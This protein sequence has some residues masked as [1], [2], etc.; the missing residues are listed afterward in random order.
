MPMTRSFSHYDNAQWQ[1]ASL[2]QYCQ[3]LAPCVL[4]RT[5]CI[6]LLCHLPKLA[7]LTDSKTG[8]VLLQV[9]KVFPAYEDDVGVFPEGRIYQH[10]RPWVQKLLQHG[11]ADLWGLKLHTNVIASPELLG[12]LPLRHLDLEI[13]GRSPPAHLKAITAALGQ[14]TTLEYL[15]ISAV[16]YASAQVSLPDLCR[17]K[18]SNLTH[19]LLRRC[20]PE[21]NLCL[22]PG[23]QLRLDQIWSP[24]WESKW[25][26]DNG[27]ELLG[28]LPAVSMGFR[29]GHNLTS[30]SFPDFKVVQYLHLLY[31]RDLK[32]LAVLQGIPHVEVEL[33]HS[34]VSLLHSAGSWKSLQIKGRAGFSYC[35]SFADI[36]AFLRH[37][38]A[39]RSGEAWFRP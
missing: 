28:C 6:S 38:R 20:F 2:P 39:Q 35:I 1:C 23:C 13:D 32:D 33:P 37:A 31:P 8:T 36:V 12:Q 30:S 7:E 29:Y 11:S 10:L 27:R 3:R 5:T 15:L 19:V 22:P 14:C 25:Q 26:S 18:A 9:I 21:G 24:C 4:P 16:R 17:Y 34:Q